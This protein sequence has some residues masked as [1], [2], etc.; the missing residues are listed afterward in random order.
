M[1]H[2][3]EIENKINGY[4]E[5]TGEEASVFFEENGAAEEKIKSV[6]AFLAVT[7]PE[8]FQWFLKKYGSGGIEGI[9]LF[10]I[11]CEREP[12]DCTLV[13]MTKEYR[14]KGM[15]QNLVVIEYEGDYVRCL[16]T[17]G[18]AVVTWSPHDRDGIVVE[19]ENF[20]TYFNEKLDD[21]V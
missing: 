3:E 13:I 10:G 7:L 16:E 17:D 11:E 15:P 6:E 5:E 12:Q 4:L 8:S 1:F 18:G 14:E 21:Y 2:Y 20:Y 9:E 19:A